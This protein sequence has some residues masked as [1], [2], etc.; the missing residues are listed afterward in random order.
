[1]IQNWVGRFRLGEW[2]PIIV[3]TSNDSLTPTKADATP[4]AVVY[5]SS[6]SPVANF[7]VPIADQS[8]VTG[9]F[10]ERIFLDS[11][12]STGYHSVIIHFAVGS[13]QKVQVVEFEIVAGGDSD[14]SGISLYHFRYPSRD[15]VLVQT[16]GGW[17]RKLR[18]PR[19]S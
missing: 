14:G 15:Y 7:K 10:K 6:G 19:I 16:D 4:V 11:N 17:L 2:V 8:Y 3:R 13:V 5:D 1:M 9:L 18:N 12:F